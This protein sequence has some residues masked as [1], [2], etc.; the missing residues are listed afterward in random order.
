MA[1]SLLEEQDAASNTTSIS[2]TLT[3]GKLADSV[4]LI[5]WNNFHALANLLPPTGTAVNWLPL[6]HSLDGGT[7][8]L[9]CKVW[10]GSIVTRLGTVLVNNSTTDEE[11]Y[12]AVFVF[13]GQCDFDVAASTDS[14]VSGTSMVAPSVTPAG[15]DDLLVCSWASRD[16]VVNIT[17]PGSMTAYTERDLDTFA[18][19]RS[20]SEQ[21][22]SGGATGTRTGT[23]SAS[24]QWGA[25]S[26]LIKA[27]PVPVTGDLRIPYRRIGPVRQFIAGQR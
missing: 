22:V 21:L 8:D 2:F 12:A 23:A 5:Q 13:D 20:A 6:Q 24:N 1:V 9:H 26:V 16:T 7:G 4:L 10:T 18:T 15:T 17:V 25:V 11:R 14:D 19:F 3:A 27:P